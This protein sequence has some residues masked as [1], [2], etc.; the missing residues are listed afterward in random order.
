LMLKMHLV[1]LEMLLR[2]SLSALQQ[3]PLQKLRK[4]LDRARDDGVNKFKVQ[5][6]R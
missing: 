5:Q 3:W 1:S 2:Y 6:Y 4:A